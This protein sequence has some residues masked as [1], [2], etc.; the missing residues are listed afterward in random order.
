MKESFAPKDIFPKKDNLLDFDPQL[1]NSSVE[2]DS[3]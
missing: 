3:F 1:L 2:Q